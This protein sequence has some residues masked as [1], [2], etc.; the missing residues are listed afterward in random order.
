MKRSLRNA[1]TV[2]CVLLLVAAS[3]AVP[4]VASDDL[5]DI[6]QGAVVTDNSP[7]QSGGHYSDITNMFGECEGYPEACNTLFQDGQPAGTLHW[8]E[9]QTPEPVT[10]QSFHLLAYHDGP[11]RDA[12]ARGFSQFNL[13]YHDGNDW[14][15]LY[16]YFPSNPYGMGSN[17]N[18]LALCD[19]VSE[20]NAQHF[21]AEF[22]QY[23]NYPAADAPRI[24]E[25]DG[26][27]TAFYAGDVDG[28]AD[29]DLADLAI[30]LTAYGTSYGDPGYDGTADI[31]VDADVDLEDLAA[32][33]ADYGAGS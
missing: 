7:V 25:L 15:E 3:Q 14:V 12:N 10:L 33:L 20:T 8:V 11:P 17:G 13:Y 31:D 18:V 27:S 22:V 28:D 32:L 19:N 29:V 24:V 5:W 1:T 26:F 21:R 9:W 16:E 2:F 23:G 6:T 30:L 4:P